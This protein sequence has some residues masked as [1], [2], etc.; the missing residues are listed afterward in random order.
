M[1]L[2]KAFW[3]GI[4]AIT[5]NKLRLLLTVL[6]IVIGVVVCGALILGAARVTYDF[7]ISDITDTVPAFSQVNNQIYHVVNIGE[8][9]ASITDVKADVETILSESVIVL[10]FINITSFLPNNALGFVPDD[11]GVA[12]ELLGENHK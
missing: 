7:E 3:S 10:V 11:F 8:S 5:S 12:L 2:T 1:N 6:G 4:V 9:I